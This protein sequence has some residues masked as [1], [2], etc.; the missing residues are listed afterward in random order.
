MNFNV[1][2]CYALYCSPMEICADILLQSDIIDKA[3]NLSY[4]IVI[5]TIRSD[6]VSQT[7]VQMTPKDDTFSIVH[8]C[9]S[10]T[11]LIN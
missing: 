11:N 3:L 1:L 9:M 2:I 8:K 4:L 10:L 6:S 5:A 7:W